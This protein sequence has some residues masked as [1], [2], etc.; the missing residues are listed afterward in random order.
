MAEPGVL[1]LAYVSAHPADAARVLESV[2]AS[3]AAELFARLP[4]RAA[5]PALTA[6]LPPLAARVLGALDDERTLALLSAGG[7]QGAVAILRQIPEPRRS[8]LLNGLS[9]M[10]AVVSR[11]LLGYS[12][13]TVG[14]WADPEMLA[15]PSATT[16][17]EALARVRADA[18]AE[19]SELYIVA[20]AGRL[21]G[22]VA[23]AD[24]LRA[25][26]ATSVTSLS[27]PPAATLPASTP[28]DGAL[29][30]PAWQRT[31]ILPVVE[32]GERLIGVLRLA[33]LH[34]AV[35]QSASVRR[36]SERETTLAAVA[37]SS[38]WVAVSGL[39]QSGLQLMP[40]LKP[41]LPEER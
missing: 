40:G 9:T 27:R 14:A 29:A 1:T 16:A 35:A 19:A 20:E 2:R 37:A 21:Q 18:D 32:R 12:D 7:A 39:V 13:E 8:R 38:Y 6:M 3:E 34:E 17:D 5:A 30:H 28:L 4:A 15:L 41:V 23:L 22:V 33:K 26:P 11:M 36:G 31:S 24:L 10:T 25:P